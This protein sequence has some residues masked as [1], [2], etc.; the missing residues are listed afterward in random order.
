[1]NSMNLGWAGNAI[2]RIRTEFWWRDLLENVHLEDLEISGRIALRWIL[3]RRCMKTGGGWK[4][5][6][7]V[8]NGSTWN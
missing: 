6:R 7:I 1:M 4:W 8:F 5:P 3:E 2:K